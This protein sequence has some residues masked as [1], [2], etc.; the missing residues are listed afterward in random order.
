MFSPSYWLFLFPFE[1]GR[2]TAFWYEEELSLFR[3]KTTE[4][5]EHSLVRIYASGQDLALIV[6]S[7]KAKEQLSISE[8]AKLTN[9]S[10]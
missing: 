8:I 5:Q 4:C 1:T 7:L 10:F 9:L 3:S 6:S 2:L